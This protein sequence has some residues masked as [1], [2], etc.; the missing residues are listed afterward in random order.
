MELE[1]HDAGHVHEAVL[2]RLR[3]PRA[4]EGRRQDVSSAVAH[5]VDV[6]R[7]IR[8]K[9]AQDGDDDRSRRERHE[10]LVE[11]AVSVRRQRRRRHV[12]KSEAAAHVH[13]AGT[14][15]HEAV[16][17]EQVR[18]RHGAVRV[19]PLAQLSRDG[20]PAAHRV[21]GAR[22]VVEAVVCRVVGRALAAHVC[23]FF[24]PR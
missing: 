9:Q 14:D 22:R 7:R 24:L 19:R 1:P 12:G 23:L 3:R 18:R 15:A 6:V 21:G 16:H 4:I 10:H 13:R 20:G 2:V 8:R 17:G 5:L 11:G